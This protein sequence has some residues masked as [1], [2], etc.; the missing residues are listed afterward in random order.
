MNS[1]LVRSCRLEEVHNVLEAIGRALDGLG[2]QSVCVL[3]CMQ[4][5]RSSFYHQLERDFG[6]SILLCHPHDGIKAVI[7]KIALGVSALIVIDQY[8]T[9]PSLFSR[10]GEQATAA[11][12]AINRSLLAVVPDLARLNVSEIAEVIKEDPAHLVY[13]VDEDAAGEDGRVLE[14]LSIGVECPQ[15]LR[16]AVG[17][18]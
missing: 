17:V 18:S 5:H 7:G 1:H 16:E 11:L 2:D 10:V 9:L 4:P 3:H 6:V 15:A 13:Q 12:Y 8:G 14:V